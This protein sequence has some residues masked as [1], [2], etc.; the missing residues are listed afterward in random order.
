M[1]PKLNFITSFWLFLFFLLPGIS[2]GE[3]TADPIGQG[4]SGEVLEYKVGFWIFFPVGGGMA[5]FRNLGNGKYMVFH[6]GKADGLMGWLT[7]Y[8]RE[9]YRSMMGTINN[10]QRLIP[11]RFEENSIIG[12]WFRKKTTVYDYAA[13][14]VSIEIEKEGEK[15]RE[16][17][18]IPLGIVYDD[19]VTAFYNFRFG[20]YG[21]VEPGKEFILRTLPRKGEET[22][23]LRVAS[24]EETA[25]KRAEET[26]KSGKEFFVRILLNREMWGRKKGELEIWFNREL[27]PISGVVKDIRF[28]G[29]V[30][31]KLT[32]RGLMNFSERPAPPSGK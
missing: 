3:N 11:L 9:V 17:L 24:K 32:Y 22:I 30:K 10:G 15:N 14:K 6:E 25:I 13:R 27:V 18:E 29:D 1:T 19:P 26:D 16:E 2:R 5:D 23:R 4:F 7:R 31:G 28:F 20:V 8:R 21:K 12:K